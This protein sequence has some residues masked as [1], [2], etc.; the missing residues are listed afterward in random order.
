VKARSGW[1][2]RVQ[3]S[4]SWHYYG[5]VMAYLQVHK[6]DIQEFTNQRWMTVSFWLML[7]FVSL[8]LPPAMTIPVPLRIVVK[9][10]RK[11]NRL[12]NRVENQPTKGPYS[13]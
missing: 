4:F 9:A 8:S 1:R 5:A 2:R 3:W 6:Y 10:H 12:P 13:R 11:T 7:I